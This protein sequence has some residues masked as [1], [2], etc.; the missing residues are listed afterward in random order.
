M[1]GLAA[2]ALLVSTSLAIGCGDDGAASDDGSVSVDGGDGDLQMP[3]PPAPPMASTRTCPTGWERIDGR[4]G[5]A[6]APWVDSPAC[7]PNEAQFP[8]D[9][10]CALVGAACP[11]GEFADGLPAGTVYV[12]EG[13]SGGDGTEASPLGELGMALALAG[14]GGTI[15]LSAGTYEGGV[16]LPEGVT[17]RGACASLTTITSTVESSPTDPAVITSGGGTATL[18]DLTIRSPLRAGVVVLG[19]GNAI[20]AQGVIIADSHIGGV[21]ASAGGHFVGSEVVI[22]GTRPRDDGMGGTGV[23]AESGGSAELHRAIVE[24]NELQGVTVSTTRGSLFLEDVVVRQTRSQ[25]SDGDFGQGVAAAGGASVEAHRLVIEDSQ[26]GGLF[27]DGVDTSFIGEDVVV[28]RTRPRTS[29]ETLGRG[30]S[31]VL[32]ATAI[33]HGLLVEDSVDAGLLVGGDRTTFTGTDG[34]IRRTMSAPTT[35]EDGAGAFVQMGGLLTLERVAVEEVRS[36]GVFAVGLGSS[37]ELTDVSVEAVT[38]D[39]RDLDGHGMVVSEGA[40]LSGTRV[41]IEESTASGLFVTDADSRAEIED[42]SIRATAPSSDGGGGR[43]INVQD[44]ASLTLTRALVEAN[45]ETG[46]FVDG[47][48]IALTDVRVADTQ[49]RADGYGG[50]GINAQLSSTVTVARVAVDGSHEVGVLLAGGSSLEGEDLHV[51]DT[52]ESTAP[53]GDGRGMSIQLSDATLRRVSVRDSHGLGIFVYGVSHLEA[54]AIVV[55]DTVAADCSITTCTGTLAHGHGVG[56]Y[57]DASAD[58]SDLLIQRS[59][60]CGIHIGEGAEVDLANGVIRE[61]AIGACVQNADLDLA[62]LQHDV[63]YDDNGTNLEATRLPVPMA[64]SEL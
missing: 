47:S 53:G 1:K 38:A 54:S 59:A 3:A 36:V 55:E 51:S 40:S 14:T 15:A 43:G 11:S 37:A 46:I 44:G 62:R 28:R 4:A 25:R 23:S 57:G 42:A 9:S 63:A 30:V 8:G 6:C 32:G 56:V 52:R 60:V 49:L 26:H 24:D 17:I 61:N 48:A 13:A 7:G 5:S 20:A 2:A 34:L 19:D 12:R 29:D 16:V 50:R 22:R 45:H 31:V 64:S 39:A 27:L 35:G 41:H 58:L 33:I 18:R 10:A 21:I